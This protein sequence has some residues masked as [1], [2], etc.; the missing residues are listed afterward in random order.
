MVLPHTTQ[1]LG[2]E[3]E[4]AP[5]GA[6]GNMALHLPKQTETQAPSMHMEKEPRQGIK[7]VLRPSCEHI[8]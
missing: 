5:I 3:L 8:T 7:A 6:G 1:E 2:V 4:N